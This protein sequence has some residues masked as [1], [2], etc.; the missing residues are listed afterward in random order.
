MVVLEIALIA[1]SIVLFL[2]ADYY[3]KGCEK[4]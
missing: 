1:G 3:V 2:S 4:V